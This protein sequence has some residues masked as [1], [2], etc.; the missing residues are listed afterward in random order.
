MRKDKVKAFE[1]R[2]QE[3]SYSEI[4]RILKI[5]KGTLAHWFKKEE[6]SKEIQDKLKTKESL[7][8][9]K[10]LAYVQK[11]NRVRWSTLRQNYRDDAIKEFHKHKNNPLFLAGIML[12]WGE[13]DKTDRAMVK[14]T[15]SDPRMVS[16][17]YKFL[18]KELDIP[19][20]K[21]K[22]YLL[23]Y[24]DLNDSM[25]KSFWQKAT[26]IP[27]DSFW[28]SIFIKGRHPSRRLSY[29]VCNINIGSRALKERLLVWVNLYQEFLV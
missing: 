15:N 8:D 21:I 25:Q 2:R 13:G 19:E 22:A 23:L 17:F 28:N 27:K 16:L 7:S 24:P 10:K 20:S 12:Y 5:P 1:L 14:F 29:G 26:G 4:N 6:W 9:P 18:R 11:A 3:K